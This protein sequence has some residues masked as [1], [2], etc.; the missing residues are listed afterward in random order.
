MKKNIGTFMFALSLLVITL[1]AMAKETPSK[2]VVAVVNGKEI[3]KQ[4]VRAM[5][6][7]LPIQGGVPLESVFPMVIDQMINETLLQSEAD[8]LK[9]EL[10]RDPKVL[11]MIDRAKEQIIRSVYLDRQVTKTVK[12]SDVKAEYQKL[13]SEAKGKKEAHARHILVKTEDE[14]KAVIEKLGKGE[15]F[16]K[17]AETTSTGPS[18]PRGGDLGYFIKEA[19][20]PE[21][22]DVAFSLKAGT[23]SKKPV[24]TQF[25]WHIIK[26]EDIRNISVPEFK[27]VENAIR[28]RLSQQ[29][30]ETIVKNLRKTADIKRFSL[31][32]KPL[33]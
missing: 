2:V 21:F 5:V 31:D 25:G 13:K 26:T 33:N 23:Y 15:D 1:P 19:M 8:K 29:A 6:D 10:E 18:A 32:G 22:S 9:V 11:D 28:T 30:L 3:Y 14:A 24:K 12:D 27:T 4:D 20:V 16:A 17:L 7:S